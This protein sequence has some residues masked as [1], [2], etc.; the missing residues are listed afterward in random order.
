MQNAM[1]FSYNGISNGLVCRVDL[2]HLGLACGPRKGTSKKEQ[3]RAGCGRT[4]GRTD[5]RTPGQRPTPLQ[6][7]QEKKYA[8]RGPTPSVRFSYIAL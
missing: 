1:V 8:F 5:G 4:H 2:G 6:H 7:T 3:R